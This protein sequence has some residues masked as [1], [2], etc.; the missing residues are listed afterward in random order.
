MIN[1]T[2]RIIV[3]INNREKVLTR[4]GFKKNESNMLG[5]IRLF[6]CIGHAKDYLLDIYS[7]QENDYELVK[8]KITYEEVKEVE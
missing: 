3:F 4:G 8:V 2:T 6:N 1:C 7:L 5:E